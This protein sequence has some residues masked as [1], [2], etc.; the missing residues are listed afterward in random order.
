MSFGGAAARAALALSV[1]ICGLTFSQIALAQDAQAEAAQDAPAEPA[2]EQDAVEEQA[3][4][5]KRQRRK[6]LDE[7]IVTAQKT[8]QTIQ[9]VPFSVSAIGAEQLQEQQIQDFE[10][11][12]RL[13]PNTQ[14]QATHGFTSINIRG[15]GSPA[16][17]GFEQSVSIHVDNVYYARPSYI[18]LAFLDLERI[19]ILR[20]PQ[21]TL[22]GK[23]SIAGAVNLITANPGHEWEYSGRALYGSYNQRRFEAMI[24]APVVEDKIAVRAAAYYN[25]RD[26]YVE[27][28]LRGEDQKIIDTQAARIK[29]LWDPT[30]DL[31]IVAGIQYDRIR[32]NGQGWEVYHPSAQTIDHHRRYVPDAEF[33]LDYEGYENLDAFNRTT[34]LSGTVNIVWD[35]PGFS[36]HTTMG[37]SDFDE[38]W[39][40]DGDFGPSTILDI[41]NDDTYRQYTLETRINSA[42]GDFEYV[43]GLFFFRSDY[44]AFSDLAAFSSDE[45]LQTALNLFAP[46]GSQV[47]V[48]GGLVDLLL[49]GLEPVV[50]LLPLDEAVA[51]L[52][53]DGI[54]QTFDQTTTTYAVFGQGTWHI[55]DRWELIFG[56]RAT[57][58]TKKAKISQAFKRSGIAVG[59]IF[60]V[61][62]YQLEEERSEFALTPKVSL[63]Y[64][65]S[66]ELVG[67]VTTAGGFKAGGFNPLAAN[68]TEATF[69]NESSRTIEAGLKYA[70][71]GNKFTVNA[72]FFYT[73][74]T[75]LQVNFFDGTNFFADNAADARTMG[76][77]IESTFILFEGFYGR[78]NFAWLDTL[79]ESYPMG[80]CPPGANTEFCDLTGLEL[81][82][83][84][85]FAGN[86]GGLYTTPLFNWPLQFAIGADIIY[87]GKMRLGLVEEIESQDAYFMFNGFVGIG[88]LDD[89]WSLS[90]QGKNLSDETILL[91]SGTVPV[92][93]ESFAGWAETP[94]T[95][96]AELTVR[97]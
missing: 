20:G 80:P 46:G 75:D 58:E 19:E 62:A 66:E 5:P 16:N 9:E 69:E 78:A 57:Y 91:L 55:T 44:T 73:S 54:L 29:V 79:Y 61:E 33:D 68:K 67:Y 13:T 24:N 84:P 89:R 60:D 94:R 65:F 43:A 28:N 11:I 14:I 25:K 86:I 92:Q 32:D 70:D 95:I 3:S 48:V 87:Q 83:T 53:D 90:I 4:K 64:R 45:G 12:S 77:E 27:N 38:E 93:G 18:H 96:T 49:S 7:V 88:D 15:L 51:L 72:G 85:T 81:G 42:P 10:D 23:N 35:Q 71:D 17:D 37:I 74:F 31:S 63:K 59:I 22:F 30:A 21:G 6:T 50:G 41:L 76:V 40:F 8:E 2:A 34:I 39:R 82:R 36:W 1:G 47:P 56:A 26:G 97:F 52:I